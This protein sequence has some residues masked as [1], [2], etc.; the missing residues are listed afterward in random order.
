MKYKLKVKE[1]GSSNVTCTLIDPMN[2]PFFR[3]TMDMEL[4]HLGSEPRFGYWL[5]E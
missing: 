4:G 2:V 1:S 5:I 3:S